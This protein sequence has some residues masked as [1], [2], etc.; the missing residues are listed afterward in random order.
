MNRRYTWNKG[1]LKRAYMEGV[2]CD[3]KGVLRAAGKGRHFIVLDRVNSYE[4]KSGW[5]RLK[6]ETVMTS[7]CICSVLA[8]ATDAERR[9]HGDMAELNRYFKS[10][11]I[12]PDVKKNRIKQADHVKAV[13][14]MDM[15]LYE[16]KGQYLWI[17]IEIFG[18]GSCEI[19]SIELTEGDNFMGTFP[20]IY[21][22]EGSFFH[23]YMSIFS[24][25]YNDINDEFE[26]IDTYLDLDTAPAELLPVYAKWLGLEPGK[27]MLEEKILRRLVKNAYRLNKM[28]GTLKAVELLAE[29]ITGASAVIIDYYTAAQNMEGKCRGTGPY[30]GPDDVIII[31]SVPPDKRLHAQLMYL[32]S[33]FLPVHCKVRLLF[34]P[35][36]SILGNYGYMDFNAALA[37]TKDAV[38]DAGFDTGGLALR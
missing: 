19:R 28:K 24:S 34:I 26:R 12:H 10:G 8:F 22:D 13:G 21:Q 31:S 30:I 9:D 35:K 25:I 32:S 1:K 5:G 29:I 15:L 33:Q 27:E 14:E 37:E 18:K 2:V 6:L 11:D 7:D 20:E 17:C 4:E 16:L 23:R 38:L 36:C 3:D